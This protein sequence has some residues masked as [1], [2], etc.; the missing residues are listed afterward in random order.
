MVLTIGSGST[1]KLLS[2]KKTK[3]FAELLQG[4]VADHRPDWNSYASPIDAL[5]TGAIL[6]DRY[7]ETLNLD[8]YCQYK[9]Q[10]EDMDCLVAS[11]DFAK[12]EKGKMV[13][14]EELKTIFFTDFL[15]IIKPLEEMDDAEKLAVI[16]KKFKNN[17]RQVQFQLLCTGLDS[18]LLVF[19]SAE[20]YNDEENQVREIQDRDIIKIRVPRDEKLIEQIKERAAIF[21]SIK[22]ELK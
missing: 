15:S 12:F 6:E 10:C 8:Y 11:I 2:G 13:D 18:A 16:K 4:F 9:A 5:R 1:A 21:Q 7:V 14:F 19:L 17:Y 3:G 20:T 22:D